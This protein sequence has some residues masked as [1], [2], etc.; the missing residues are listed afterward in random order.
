MGKF[1]GDFR[2]L[3]AGFVIA[4]DV[5]KLILALTGA[6][7][8][9][10]F[11]GLPTP[12]WALRY[13]AGFSAELGERGPA[14]YLVMIPDAVC[15]LW[16]EGGW[17][18]A[19][20]CAFLLAVVTTVWSLFGTAISRIAAVEIAREDR[21]R[22]QEALGFALSR[23]ASNLSSPIACIL[24]FLFFTSLVALLGLPGRIPGIG[25][26]ASIL[27]ALVFPFGLLGGFI[28]TLIALG[29]VFGYP[30][31]YP[32]VAA[33]GTDAFDAISRGFSYVYS[34]PWHAL[35]YLFTAVVHGVISTA[36]IWAF[37]AV[38]L[39]VTCAA[40][41]LGMGAGK[42]DLILEFTTG[43]ATWDTVVAD[44]GTGLGIAAILITTWILLT[45][46][47]TLVYALSY[48]QSQLT[49][50]YFL[51]R[52][53]VDELPMSYVWEE[54]EAA[55]AGDPPGAEGEAAAPGPGGNGDG[56]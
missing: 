45:A 35:W 33:E 44:G 1:R 17:V 23:W 7:L 11:A 2:D 36:F 18:F 43:R 51:L 38:M 24:G 55:P 19:G 26:W 37:G 14:G 29:A 15:V 6:I 22:T 50:I 48:M 9:G 16:R 12:W 8:I 25:G 13:D 21:I 31:F 30:L 42:F 4:I 10:L 54:K 41:R 27:T 3:F 34:R 20:W 40:V 56:A 49:M 47:L 5:R 32:A 52:L 39:A 53:R 46:G 28:A